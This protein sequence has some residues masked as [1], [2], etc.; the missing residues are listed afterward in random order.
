VKQ[1]DEVNEI[2]AKT[3]VWA[4]G[5][6]A[7][8]M[9]KVLGDRLNASLDRAGRVIVEPNL[10]IAG[11]PDVFVIGD[12]A[13]FP[14][15]NERP[16]PGV[17]PVAMQEGQYVAKLIKQRINHSQEMEPFRYLEVGSLAVI[18]QNAAVVDLGFVKFSGFFA[19]L[20]WIFAHVYYLIEFDNKMVVMLQWGWNYFTRG[21]GARLITGEKD[22]VSG[23]K[24]YEDL[25]EKDTKVN[26]KVEA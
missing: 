5:V 1:G 8:G 18:G 6:T 20:V 13:N 9:G 12:L 2:A 11:Y 19:W 14:H 7:S 3:I 23:F 16:L 24:L 25:A 21:R 4:A 17:A 22:L 15:Q 26:I 10:S